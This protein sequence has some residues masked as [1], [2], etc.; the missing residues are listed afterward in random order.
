MSLIRT[1]INYEY[2]IFDINNINYTA[3]NNPET[4]EKYSKVSG[5]QPPE[6]IILDILKPDLSKLRMLDIGV[7]T[8]RTTYLFAH[9]VKEYVVIDYSPLMIEQC[10]KLFKPSNNLSFL[11]NDVLDLNGY[12]DDYFD[13]VFFGFNGI[14]YLSHEEQQTAFENILRVGKPGGY[15]CFSTHNILSIENLFK[16]YKQLTP[17]PKQLI[18]NI[19][20]WSKLKSLYPEPEKLYRNR[21]YVIF[22]DGSLNFSL[23]TYYIKPVLQKKELEKNFNNIIVIDSQVKKI[24]DEELYSVK[25]NW[26]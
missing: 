3:Y 17:A 18:R 22:N 19:Y 14:D 24:N 11:V 16:F 8:G 5:L 1:T 12:E 20:T 2:L 10:K 21:D 13:F 15:F 6:K 25:D 4:V 26:L 9:L 23:V 7:G